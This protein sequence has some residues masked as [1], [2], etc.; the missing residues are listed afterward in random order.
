MQAFSFQWQAPRPLPSGTSSEA[1][2]APKFKRNKITAAQQEQLVAA[3]EQDNFL[4]FD[5][6]QQLAERLGMAPRSVQIWFQ[7]RRQRFVKTGQR[8]SRLPDDHEHAAITFEDAGE[9]DPEHSM[10]GAPHGVPPGQAI[11]VP[12]APITSSASLAAAPSPAAPKTTASLSAARAPT[13]TG[14]STAGLQWIPINFAPTPSAQESHPTCADPPWMNTRPPL[15]DG[16]PAS[17]FSATS[18]PHPAT[19]APGM[20]DLQRVVQQ[21]VSGDGSLPPIQGTQANAPRADNADLP[22]MVSRLGSLLF[23]AGDRPTGQIPPDETLPHALA[24][25]P[26]AISAGYVSPE[27]ANLL[28]QQLLHIAS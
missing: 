12:Q 21:L 9:S 16:V 4:G 7:N 14:T 28:Q 6:R 15:S 25:L 17:T 26:K 5:E 13:P 24:M 18:M 19:S 20:H 10:T 27:A 22:A 2:V 3:F 23:E 11:S 8:S 1:K